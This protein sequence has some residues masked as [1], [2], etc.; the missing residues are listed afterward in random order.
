MSRTDKDVPYW[1][2]CAQYRAVHHWTC[3]V[4]RKPCTLPEFLYRGQAWHHRRYTSCYWQGVDEVKYWKLSPPKWY[5]D[6]RWN[7]PQR[8]EV[9]DRARQMI[10]EYQGSGMVED[11]MPREQHRHGATWDYW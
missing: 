2:R 9:R 7:N 11:I 5:R 6:H 3:S 1:M 10:A 4:G 8:V